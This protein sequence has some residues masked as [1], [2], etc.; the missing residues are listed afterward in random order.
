MRAREYELLALGGGTLIQ[1]TIPASEFNYSR[2]IRD[3]LGVR[4]RGQK[5]DREELGKE[6]V[7]T[8]LRNFAH[9]LHDSTLEIIKS[10]ASDRKLTSRDFHSTHCLN[11]SGVSA[12]IR[13]LSL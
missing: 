5:T 9:G 8:I 7:V 1:L 3:R 6:D 12:I 13:L 4:I 11:S 2:Q 10:A